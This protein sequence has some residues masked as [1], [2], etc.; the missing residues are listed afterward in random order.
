M[1]T[2]TVESL[3]VESFPTTETA[4]ELGAATTL[5]EQALFAPLTVYTDPCDRN[6]Q[7]H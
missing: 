3:L 5:G 4:G 7:E 2:L 1:I 6:C